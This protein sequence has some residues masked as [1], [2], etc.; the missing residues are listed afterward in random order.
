MPDYGKSVIIAAEDSFHGY[1]NWTHA[2]NYISQ[3]S[4]T[5]QY[6]HPNGY[7]LNEQLSYIVPSAGWITFNG[8]LTADTAT[9]QY[10]PTET[11]YNLYQL[12]GWIYRDGTISN[13]CTISLL[14]GEPW[15]N[16]VTIPVSPGDKLY[17]GVIIDDILGVYKLPG[18]YSINFI[19][20][21]ILDTRTYN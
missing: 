20:G 18:D 6:N 17:Y 4:Q 7:C 16:T 19:P 15:N 2:G 8:W 11:P 13:V 3:Y 1:L 12:C 9:S 5:Y 21:K 10:F 14:G